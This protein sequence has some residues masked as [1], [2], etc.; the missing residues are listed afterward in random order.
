MLEIQAVFLRIHEPSPGDGSALRRSG[1][2]VP[3]PKFSSSVGDIAPIFTTCF[4]FKQLLALVPE[5]I[6]QHQ[7]ITKVSCENRNNALWV[8][9]K[10][11]RD[12]QA[13]KRDRTQD[14]A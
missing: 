11:K 6:V 9:P 13:T 1:F 2:F 12:I 7:L 10:G 8:Q 14:T 5:R 4:N 3:G